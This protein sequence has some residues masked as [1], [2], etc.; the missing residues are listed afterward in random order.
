M[1]HNQAPQLHELGAQRVLLADFSASCICTLGF[2]HSYAFA[3]SDRF[4]WRNP[5]RTAG[6]VKE[7]S[8]AYY[9]S[10]TRSRPQG[11]PRRRCGYWIVCKLCEAKC[12]DLDV[13]Q[14]HCQGQTHSR[15]MQSRLLSR[16]STEA[17]EA[18]LAI[19][20]HLCRDEQQRCVLARCYGKSSAVLRRWEP[21]NQPDYRA[22]GA[23]G[24]EAAPR[25]G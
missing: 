24:E 19:R 4:C 16:T 13:T 8:L 6:A 18:A 11:Q 21:Q 1:E 10:G 2:S 23:R 12:A 5:W 15:R 3:S 14:W 25:P 22:Q 20:T 7:A 17:L 9:K